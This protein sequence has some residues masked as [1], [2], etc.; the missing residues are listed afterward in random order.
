MNA[1]QKWAINVTRNIYATLGSNV[2]IRCSFSSPLDLNTANVKVF[3]K[4]NVSTYVFHANDT[5]VL[6]MYRG[7][8]KLLG[9]K[10]QGNCSLMIQN[11][12]EEDHHIY[13]RVNVNGEEYSFKKDFVRITLSGKHFSDVPVYIVNVCSI[14]EVNGSIFSISHYLRSMTTFVTLV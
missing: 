4:K 14:T 10:K 11:I 9:K 8:T 1:G 5:Y 13:L 7:K 2:T 3:W 12:R 6:E